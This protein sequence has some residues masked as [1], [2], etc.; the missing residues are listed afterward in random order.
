MIFKKRN[1]ASNDKRHENRKSFSY[2]MQLTN[3][4]TK[5]VVGHLSDISTGGFKLDSDVPL[6]L[7]KD[8]DFHLALSSDVAHKPYMIFRARSKWCKTDPIDPFV[9]N[10]GFHL[11]AMDSEDREIFVRVMEK[12]GSEKSS[13]DRKTTPQRSRSW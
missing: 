2:Y 13:F 11:I 8:Y 5:E 9:Y 4:N 6:P 7:N 3:A 12:Y 1:K 10:I